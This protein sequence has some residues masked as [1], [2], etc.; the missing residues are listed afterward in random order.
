MVPVLGELSGYRQTETETRL[1]HGK[2]SDGHRSPGQSRGVPE[3]AG[4]WGRGRAHLRS[5]LE[6]GAREPGGTEEPGNPRESTGRPDDGND[7]AKGGRGSS[8]RSRSLT[9]RD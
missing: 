1:H 7:V 2:L 3:A 4:S 8:G 5:F 6:P 9:R